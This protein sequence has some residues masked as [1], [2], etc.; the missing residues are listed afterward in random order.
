MSA[1]VFGSDLDELRAL[2]RALPADLAQRGGDIVAGKTDE[3]A[4]AIYDA[5]PDRTGHLR[6]GVK[7][8][9]TRSQYGAVGTL[10][11]TSKLAWIFEN[12]TQARHTAIGAD[13][14]SMPAGKV[15]VP[16]VIV[17]RREMYEELK[18]MLQDHPL[19]LEVSGDA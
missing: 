18:A 5:Y 16:I 2:L 1:G 12:G 9:I 19:G 4:T 7:Y 8:T 6:G 13:R 10:K 3:A 11:N 15:F 17:K 14:G